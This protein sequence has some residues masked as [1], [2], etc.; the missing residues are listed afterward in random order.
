MIHAL[1]C[2]ATMDLIVSLLHHWDYREDHDRLHIGYG[3][4]CGAACPVRD[5]IVL[6]ARIVAVRAAERRME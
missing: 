2:D 6:Q 1:T 4:D 3:S 5:H